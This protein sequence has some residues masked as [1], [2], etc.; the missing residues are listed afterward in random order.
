[1]GWTP[2]VDLEAGLEKTIGYFRNKV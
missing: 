1:L 2:K